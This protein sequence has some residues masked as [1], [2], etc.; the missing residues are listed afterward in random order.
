MVCL[1]FVGNAPGVRQNLLTELL[2]TL[3]KLVTSY[4]WIQLTLTK[5]LFTQQYKFL[6]FIVPD[7][8]LK[9]HISRVC[10]SCFYQLRRHEV[11][12]GR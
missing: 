1:L 3:L 8:T 7:L 9:Q 12:A 2:C 5:T 6:S 11:S 4:C 10:V